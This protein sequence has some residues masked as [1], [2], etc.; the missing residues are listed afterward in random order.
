MMK[1]A[2]PG[3]DGFYKIAPEASVYVRLDLGQSDDLPRKG[4]QVKIR[5]DHYHHFSDDAV[6][7]VSEPITVEL[8]R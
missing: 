3:P 5:F 7:L 6:Q 8:S 4:G 1:R 2:H